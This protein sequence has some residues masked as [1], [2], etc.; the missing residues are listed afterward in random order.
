MDT[1]QN[2]PKDIESPSQ[3][4]TNETDSPFQSLIDLENHTDPH[5]IGNKQTG[6][7]SSSH[8]PMIPSVSETFNKKRDAD[9]LT[10]SLS[11]INPNQKTVF[12]KMP[13]ATSSPE[14]TLNETKRA[15]T[16]SP[17]V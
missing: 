8:M 3:N 10:R 12:Y 9:F 2:S 15:R 6:V 4:K 13:S 16:K 5:M 14:E 17:K 1:S 7:P 11:M